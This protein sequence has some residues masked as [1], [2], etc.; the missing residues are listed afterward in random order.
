MSKNATGPLAPAIRERRKALGLTQAETAELA[1]VSAKFIIDLEGGKE[2][3]R[4]D[5]VVAMLGVLGLELRVGLR[6]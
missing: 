1:G 6:E 4:L 2:S 5:K 3:V